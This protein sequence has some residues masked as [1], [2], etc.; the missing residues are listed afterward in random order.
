MLAIVG[1]QPILAGDLLGHI[2]ERLAQFEGTVPKEE[3]DK[4]R[5]MQL[6][7]ILPN[8]ISTKLAAVD[9]LRSIPPEKVGEVEAKA[10]RHFSENRL[11]E[12]LEK[13]ESST[14]AELDAKLR[15]VGSSLDKLRR[16]HTEQIMASAAYGQN[17]ALDYDPSLVEMLE[18]Y[19]AHSAEYA[20]PERL[21]WQQLTVRLDSGAS[22]EQ[23]EKAWRDLAMMGNAIK[24]G[25]S[26]E[27]VAKKSS[28]GPTASDGGSYGWTQRGTLASEAIDK[29][30]FRLP[31]QEMSQMF[32]DADGFHIVRVIERQD[33]GKVEFQEV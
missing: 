9:F 14:A 10:Y 8:A 6:Q 7:A 29:L 33:A 13:S 26:W 28:Q 5:E 30:L 15:D 25:A 2:N 3:L 16:I 11:P 21:R 20:I 4:A 17:L 27:S 24:G 19:K 32:E 23:R 12:L 18:Y 22:R 1:D 31:V